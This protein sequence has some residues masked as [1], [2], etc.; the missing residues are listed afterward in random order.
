MTRPAELDLALL[1]EEAGVDPAQL[2]SVVLEAPRPLTISDLNGIVPRAPRHLIL[3]LI[4]VMHRAG[5]VEPVAERGLPLEVRK[6]RVKSEEFRTLVSRAS[7]IAGALPWL[8]ELLTSRESYRIAATIPPELGDLDRFYG[9]FENTALGMRR[10]IEEAVREVYIVVPFFDRKGLETV[11]T[12]IEG[13]LRR[14]IKFVVLTR[15]LPEE[16]PNRRALAGLIAASKNSGGSLSLFLSEAK[17]NSPLLHAKILARDGGEEIY[18]GSANLTGAGMER[19]LEVGV[20]LRGA[21]ARVVYELVRE[22]VGAS[23]EKPL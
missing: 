20:F 19:T 21:T 6:W 5:A 4:S 16:D 11:S 13:A 17:K 7:V 23:E 1:C 14:G 18:V 3:G 2:A 10:M 9:I 22:L 15:G 12:A 8:R